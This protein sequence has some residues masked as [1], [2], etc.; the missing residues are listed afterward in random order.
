[1][2]ASYEIGDLSCYALGQIRLQPTRAGGTEYEL[3]IEL[4]YTAEPDE[5]CYFSSHRKRVAIVLPDPLPAEASVHG[6]NPHD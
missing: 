1:M 6:K 2:L 4:D 5:V 3:A